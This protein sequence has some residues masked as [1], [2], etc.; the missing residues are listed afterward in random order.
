MGDETGPLSASLSLPLPAPTG[1][2]RGRGHPSA[3]ALGYNSSGLR[4]AP[5]SRVIRPVTVRSGA[6]R[7]SSI[8]RSAAL[9]RSPLPRHALTGTLPTPAKSLLSPPQNPRYNGV[10]QGWHILRGGCTWSGRRLDIG[11][12]GRRARARQPHP[13][14]VARRRAHSAPALAAAP[15]HHGRP[16]VGRAT[17]LLAEPRPTP[18]L[19][20]RATHG[21]TVRLRSPGNAV[22]RP[23]CPLPGPRRRAPGRRAP[24]IPPPYGPRLGGPGLDPPSARIARLSSCPEEADYSTL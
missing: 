10:H 24:R 8:V 17:P 20:A 13:P 23:T 16:R 1:R 18:R 11:R 19:T 4:A 9:S 5:R 2:G 21:N 15:A 3:H 7:R 12:R 22:A 6:V 14:P